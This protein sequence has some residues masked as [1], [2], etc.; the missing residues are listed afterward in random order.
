MAD[1][2]YFSTTKKGAQTWGGA[3]PSWSPPRPAP[4]QARQRPPPACAACG[5]GQPSPALECLYLQRADRHSA[6]APRRPA[7]CHPRLPAAAAAFLCRAAPV[8]HLLF[9]LASGLWPAPTAAARSRLQ[10][11]ST[12]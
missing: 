7:A 4:R 3:R 2:K 1:G 5:P 12:S 9:P 10:V 6:P 8:A 11:R